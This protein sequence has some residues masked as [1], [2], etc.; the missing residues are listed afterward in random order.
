MTPFDYAAIGHATYLTLSIT[1]TI[2]V[3]RTLHRHG[4]TFLIDAMTG[5]QELA[6]S[7]NT[8]LVM[9]FYLLNFGFVC[10][11]MRTGVVPINLAQMMEIV[12]RQLGWILLFLGIVHLL[13]VFVLNRFRT[14]AIRHQ[15]PPPVSPTARL[16]SAL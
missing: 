12:S 3:A 15:L 4:R 10:L 8:L 6:N 16:D 5:N 1:M 9:G 7:I 13:N 11:A 2:W 14:R